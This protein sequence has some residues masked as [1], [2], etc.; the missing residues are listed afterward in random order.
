MED[1]QK[2]QP[3]DD[4]PQPS[5]QPQPE[6]SSLEAETRQPVWKPALK[7]AAIAFGAAAVVLVIV[8]IFIF[9][10][11]HPEF[12][13]YMDRGNVASQSFLGNQ[14]VPVR[15]GNGGYRGN[16]RLN[17]R[18]RGWRGYFRAAHPV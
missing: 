15:F 6:T 17:H 14:F 16:C 3:S 11:L 13:P 1:T 18:V 8:Y 12:V 2:T 7:E 4:E 10:S 5:G 9:R